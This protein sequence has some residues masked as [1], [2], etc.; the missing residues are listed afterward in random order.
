M[1]FNSNE[2]RWP[3]MTQM[4]KRLFYKIPEQYRH[5]RLFRD[6]YG[7]ILES[8]WWSKQALEEYQLRELCR[9]VKHA[10]E[11]VPFYRKLWAKRG[12]RPEAV[13]DFESFR[14]LP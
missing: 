2:P 12:I 9:L 3:M 4:A 13:C 10:H 1:K 14:K 11:N 6:V 7:S 5:G 8:Q